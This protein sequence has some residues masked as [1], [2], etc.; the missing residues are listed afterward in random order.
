[1]V[2]SKINRFF[3]RVGRFAAILHREYVI[4]RFQGYKQ[5]GAAIPERSESVPGISSNCKGNN[6]NSRVNRSSVRRFLERVTE[7]LRLS[8]S[9]KYKKIVT[10]YFGPEI[11]TNTGPIFLEM[12]DQIIDRQVYHFEV[13]NDHPYIIDGGANLGL[14]TIFFKQLYPNAEIVAFEPDRSMYATL[15]KNLAK[16]G[17]DDVKLVN[18]ALWSAEVEIMFMAEGTDAGRVVATDECFE[19]YMVPSVRLREYLMR[20]VDFLKLD[21]EGAELEV[22]DDCRDLLTNVRHL[23]VEYHSFVGHPQRLDSLFEILTVAG[24]RIWLES[25]MMGMIQKPMCETSSHMGMDL[26]LNIFCKRI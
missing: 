3:S 8:Q 22:L 9:R 24:F 15:C 5:N 21:I 1:M 12:Y 13:E 10:K 18:S 14:A 11:E 23:F 6:L 25:P 2:Q 7:R 20:P 16:R 19:S 4:C 17:I 26:Q